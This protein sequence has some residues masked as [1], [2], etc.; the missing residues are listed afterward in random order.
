[1]QFLSDIGTLLGACGFQGRHNSG[2]REYN[3][4]EVRS[5]VDEVILFVGI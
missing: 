2:S 4:D 3:V 5:F 1:M